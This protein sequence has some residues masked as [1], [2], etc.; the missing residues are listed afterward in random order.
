MKNKEKETF[1]IVARLKSF[2]FAFAGIRSFFRETHNAYIHLVAT[3]LV[4]V[5]GFCFHLASAEWLF[6]I[7]AMGMVWTAEAFNTAIEFL[8]DMVSPNFDKKA[9]RVKDIAAGAVLFAAITAA[10]IGILIFL[11][12][13]KNLF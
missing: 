9:G 7:V 8:V 11:P 13:I 10:I 12:H 6:L 5:A 1:S 4:V 3:V 2:R